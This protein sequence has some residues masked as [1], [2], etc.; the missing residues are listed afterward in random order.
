MLEPG[1]K[2]YLDIFLL[3]DAHFYHETSLRAALNQHRSVRHVYVECYATNPVAWVNTIFLDP[4]VY[5]SSDL[6][7][8]DFERV[9][10]LIEDV[11]RD[12][13][14]IAFVLCSTKSII[15]Q[16]I[17]ATGDRFKHYF[18]LDYEQVKSK[19]DVDLNEILNACQIENDR[20]CRALYRYDIALSFAGEQRHYADEIAQKL[21]KHHVTVFYDD[22]EQA[23]L[24]GRDLYEHLHDIYSNQAM[25]CILLAS[26]AYAN[27]L[28][29]TLERKAAQKR[30]FHEKGEPYIL[31][32]RCDDTKI[33]GLSDTVGYLD[34]NKGIEHIC[35]CAME[36]MGIIKV[37]T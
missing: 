14:Q 33:P 31:P 34:I 28:W 12:H 36:K 5:P 19:D 29:T 4:S 3:S 27:K 24:W 10:K 7:G 25:Y 17:E 21:M 30:A 13:P 1:A 15:Q 18:K 6:S 16:F 22:Y 11:P 20:N 26:H 32:V 2:R 8:Y 35:N 37:D 9:K 23:N